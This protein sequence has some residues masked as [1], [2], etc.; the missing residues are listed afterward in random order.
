MNNLAKL[1][2]LP[3]LVVL[4]AGISLADVAGPMQVI[5]GVSNGDVVF[6]NTG[7]N[8][9]VFGFSEGCQGGDCLSGFAY[10]G[11]N[12]AGNYEM[13][14]TGGVPSLGA[15]SGFIYPINL[16]GATVN[17]ASTIGSYF[18][19]GTI[20]LL[21]LSG[22]TQTPT[23]AGKLDISSTNIPEYQYSNTAELD[24]TI[25]LDDNPSIES[26][27]SG[28]NNS[29][30]GYLSSGQVAPAVPEPSSILL[31]GSGV[32]GLGILLRRKLGL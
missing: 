27:Y 8:N 15:P 13:W 17:F 32:V 6:T 25:N 29:T 20:Q 11:A 4:M 19:N 23:F 24:F 9:V 5:L 7:G 12:P 26:V 2:L 22:G 31:F 30:R 3:L 28:Q 16:N 14:I 10:Y 18:L 21:T 1:L